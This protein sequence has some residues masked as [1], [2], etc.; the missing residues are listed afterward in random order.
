[1]QIMNMDKKEL[2]YH[3]ILESYFKKKQILF[4][5]SSIA[6][7]CHVSIGLVNATVWQLEDL[8]VVRIKLRSFELQDA[9]KL[10][11]FWATKRN[12]KK[13]LVYKTYFNGTV[14]E[15][16][17]LMSNEAVFTAYSAYRLTYKDAP[18]DYDK[19]YVYSE[20]LKSIEQRFPFNKKEAPNVFV[21]KKP[22]FL[23]EKIVSPDLLYVD[24]WNLGDWFA[25][26][27]LKAL[28]KRLFH[29]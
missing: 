27:Y 28:E 8:G 25:A 11:V 4:T 21:F 17:S 20:N 22:E 6:K 5:Q 24:L 3:A 12:L 29:E 13:D 9:K 1:M 7:T 26:E 23:T 16:E 14:K 18:S 10:L 2:I 19:V 15:I